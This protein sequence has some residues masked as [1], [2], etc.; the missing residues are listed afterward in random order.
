MSPR[1][2]IF[3]SDGSVI[4]DDGED[5]EVVL[6]VPRAWLDAPKDGVLYV[7]KHRYDGKLTVFSSVDFY[8]VMEDGETYATNDMSAL[9]RKLGI[10][11]SGINVPDEEFEAA[12]GKVQAYRREHEAKQKK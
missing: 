8:T 6:K 11:K 7:V 2:V 4:E 10:C 3:Y 5:V 9:C 1:F 12:R